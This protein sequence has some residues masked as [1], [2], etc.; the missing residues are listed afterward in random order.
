[1]EQIENLHL[2]EP[3]ESPKMSRIYNAL[4]EGWANTSRSDK[5]MLNKR[6]NVYWGLIGDNHNDINYSRECELPWIFTDMPYKGRLKNENYDDSYWRFGYKSIHDTRRLNAPSDRWEAWNDTIKPWQSGG[7]HI[8]ICPSSNAMTRYMH[9]MNAEEWASMVK[10]KLKQHTNRPV[11]VRYK[12][13]AAGTS[14]PDVAKI[15]IEKDLQGC[16]AIVTSGSLT[17]IDALRNGVPVFGTSKVCPSAWCTNW[18]L[19]S[20]NKPYKYDREHLFYDLAYKQFSIREMREG[21]CYETAVR[22]LIDKE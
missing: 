19:E 15:S 3:R 11:M 13:R 20:I 18:D 6:T 10:A 12:P 4:Q 5:S 17:A 21:I 14:G 7:D 16:H 22:Y 1:M 8:L 2:V 9:G